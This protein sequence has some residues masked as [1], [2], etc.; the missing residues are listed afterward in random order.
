M[1]H[2]GMV[3]EILDPI[4]SGYP[5]V[6]YSSVGEYYCVNPV[7]YE[8]LVKYDDVYTHAR[9]CNP[10]PKAPSPLANESEV[11][12]NMPE[13]TDKHPIKHLC[14]GHDCTV[15]VDTSVY[16]CDKCAQKYMP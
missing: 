15:Q 13:T 9:I 5:R 11:I 6:K 1:D 12:I 4:D 16:Y 8:Y 3:F 2:T 10:V 14:W 7:R